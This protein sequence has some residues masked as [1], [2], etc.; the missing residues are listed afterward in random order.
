MHTPTREDNSERLLQKAGPGSRHA[1]MAR[2][3]GAIEKIWQATT[4]TALFG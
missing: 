4:S 1:L 2:K 3:S